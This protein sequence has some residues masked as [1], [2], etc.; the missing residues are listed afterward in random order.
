MKKIIQLSYSVLYRDTILYTV[1][2]NENDSTKSNMHSIFSKLIMLK[3]QQV[4]VNFN[5]LITNCM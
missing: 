1:V 3:N 5:E 4:W 2:R